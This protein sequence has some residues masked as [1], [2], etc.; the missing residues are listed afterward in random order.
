VP[1]IGH[2]RAIF[3][4]QEGLSGLLNGSLALS[5]T[6]GI[7]FDTNQEERCAKWG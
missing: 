7:V 2:F 6:V 4:S 1:N 5:V 3:G